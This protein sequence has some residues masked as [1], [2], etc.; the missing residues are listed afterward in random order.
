MWYLSF[1]C[2]TKSFAYCLVEVKPSAAST[3][4]ELKL[5][6]AE[7]RSGDLAAVQGRLSRLEVALQATFRL[8]A[9]GAVDLVPGTP[10][11][12]IPTVARVRRL[13]EFLDATVEPALKAAQA[14][15]CP[16][17][18]PELHVA[19]EW[20]MGAN[21]HSRVIAHALI[22]RYAIANVFMVAPTLKNK[23]RFGSRPDLDHCMYVERYTGRYVANKEHSKAAYAYVRRLFA[24]RG[25]A[26][27]KKME[28]D[29]ADC[30]LQVMG[31]L[32]HGDVGR[33]HQK[34]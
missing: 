14:D 13:M 1:D 31:V 16:A 17:V 23:L 24:H 11:R 6:L 33:A 28:A 20:Q 30:V 32:L 12:K 18:G 22:A 15:G 21:A 5:C 27:S 4:S 2:A 10:D 7:A 29:F 9:G 26:V 19:V 3:V 34:F 25:A 8:A